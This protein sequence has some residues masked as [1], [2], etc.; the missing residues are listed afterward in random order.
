[1]SPPTV[2]ANEQQ[3]FI[4]D[5][6]PGPKSMPQVNPRKRA[7][8]GTMPTNQLGHPSIS[9]PYQ[10]TA[11]IGTQALDW[12]YEGGNNGNHDVPNGYS[13][14]P[15]PQQQ[16]MPPETS[17]QLARRPTGHR[18]SVRGDFRAGDVESWAPVQAHGL[19]TQ[20]PTHETWVEDLGELKERAS[21]VKRESQQ[22]RKVI[23]PFIKKLR[24]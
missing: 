15:Y 9:Y 23:P 1:M 13:F 2:T 24:R 3:R 11:P 4:L 8:P 5:A 19:P 7:T 10:P 6:H 17:T 22:R 12:N 18:P 21:A 20:Q 14:N 16:A